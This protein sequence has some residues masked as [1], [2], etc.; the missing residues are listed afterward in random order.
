MDM[1]SLPWVLFPADTICH[2]YIDFC[3]SVDQF[4]NIFLTD[5]SSLGVIENELFSVPLGTV[6]NVGVCLCVCYI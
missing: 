4:Y 6:Y 5:I 3:K 1:C 2:S